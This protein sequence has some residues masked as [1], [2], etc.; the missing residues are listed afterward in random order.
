MTNG[1]A[2]TSQARITDTFFYALE[3][4]IKTYRQFA[5]SQI[6]AAGIDVT[7]D[8]WLVLKTLQENP[9]VTQQQTGA[10]VFKDFASITR[11]IHLLVAKRF[12]RRSNH[13]EDG[14]RSKLTLT[15]VG[16]AA[17]RTLEPIIRRNRRHAL[18]DIARRDIVRAH[19]LLK[20][21]VANCDRSEAS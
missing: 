13:A 10:M 4:S 14:R 12:V 15:R 18:R 20:T 2:I 8:Q 5:Q 7:I 3:R 11:I 19:A 17:I 16:V 21:I 9:D 6:A 1:A